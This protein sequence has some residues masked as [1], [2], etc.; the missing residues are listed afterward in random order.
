MHQRR[1]DGAS[2]RD[3]FAQLLRHSLQCGDLSQA[4]LARRLR[5]QGLSPVTEPRV[6]D[7]IHGRC[8]P[9]DEGVVFAIEK[10]LADTGAAVSEGDLVTRYWAARREPKQPEASETPERRGPALDAHGTSHFRELPPIWNVPYC[11]RTPSHVVGRTAS[12]VGRRRA[13][14][15]VRLS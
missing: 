11:P 13:S 3:Q 6:S 8:L 5:Q 9:R 12:R 14:V 10:I 2:S 1:A 15:P 4:T 7:W